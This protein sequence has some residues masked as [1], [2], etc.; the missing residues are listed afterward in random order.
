MYDQL[1]ARPEITDYGTKQPFRDWCRSNVIVD[2]SKD[3]GAKFNSSFFGIYARDQCPVD[4][5]VLVDF[6]SVIGL[7]VD[8][9]SGTGDS[10][11][12]DNLLLALTTCNNEE[13]Y[14]SSLEAELV[15]WLNHPKYNFRKLLG[16]IAPA[17]NEEGINRAILEGTAP[18][19]GEVS[20][21]FA[22]SK[23]K[24]DVWLSLTTIKGKLH[25]EYLRRT[26]G[27]DFLFEKFVKDLLDET[28]YPE[29]NT[30]L[31]RVDYL[32][33]M[34]QT[35]TS[36]TR[37]LISD[38][39]LSEDE[40]AK[41][42]LDKMQ[43]YRKRYNT[44]QNESSLYLRIAPIELREP[45]TRDLNSLIELFGAI[46]AG[47]SEIE[48]DYRQLVS[49]PERMIEEVEGER[50]VFQY[51]WIK[52]T[53]IPRDKYLA[54]NHDLNVWLL[55]ETKSL[56][57]GEFQFTQDDSLAMILEKRENACRTVVTTVEEM[58][59]TG[60]LLRTALISTKTAGI[61]L[62]RKL[63]VYGGRIFQMANRCM[64]YYKK[65]EQEREGSS[66]IFMLEDMVEIFNTSTG[67]RYPVKDLGMI[68]DLAPSFP[69][70][71]LFVCEIS[72]TDL[73]S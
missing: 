48:K 65:L 27:F 14:I 61:F 16:R 11:E 6:K 33:R 19:A 24:S 37:T 52:S 26:D 13:N 56:G 50:T 44:I 12:R 43:S 5:S 73:E 30:R 23:K 25:T 70:V 2:D 49:A 42:V 64:T 18:L 60:V 68:T 62:D 51:D 32:S 39:M 71:H 15:L 66:Y 41:D 34:A 10:E 40:P 17:I 21:F 45:I 31:K 67:N 35:L 4:S 46:K 9:I 28:M 3:V 8:M 69:S 1:G 58:I 36:M 47:F 20:R 57:D 22:Q 38:P 63:R 54:W 59:R 53:A 55:Q 29:L 72:K 7:V